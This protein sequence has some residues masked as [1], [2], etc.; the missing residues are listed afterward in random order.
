M[1][2][3]ILTLFFF[4]LPLLLP[5]NIQQ[6]A[7]A[8]VNLQW[9]R[10]YNGP[11]SSDDAAQ[12]ITID[13]SGNVYITGS[14]NVLG[15]VYDYATVKYSPSGET[16][17]VRRFHQGINFNGGRDIIVDESY[18]VYVT[19]SPVTIKYDR[20]GNIL[21]VFDNNADVR[22]M[23]RDNQGNLYITGTSSENFVTFKLN[24]NGILIW[25]STYNGPANGIDRAQ[26]LV[27]DNSNNIIVTGWSQGSGTLYDYAT[28]KYTSFGGTVW[29][30]RYNGP[31]P[32]YPHDFGEA[33]AVDDIGNVFVT[34]YSIGTNGSSDYL[35]IKYD[36][37][38]N[39]IWEARYDIHGD[40]GYDIS[41]DR[42][43]NIFVTGVT[44]VYDYTTL[45][46]NNSGN[47]IWAQTIPGTD[48]PPLPA[49][50]LDTLGNVYVAASRQ[51]DDWADFII[52]K[53][54]NNGIQQ[55][56]T[57]YPGFG[58]GFHYSND[59]IIDRNGIVYVTGQGYGSGFYDYHTVK[60]S[61][62]VGIQTISIEIPAD[63]SLSQN[64]PN[65]FNPSTVIRYR[66]PVNSFV[67]L[68]IYDILGREVANLV[69]GEFK[70]GTYEIKWD[71]NDLM[72]QMSTSGIYFYRLT[73]GDYTESKKMILLR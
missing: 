6:V 40:A 4:H 7:K 69:N 46:Y 66:L 72:N 63:F 24:S 25:T 60:Y 52:V 11:T 22:K 41:V 55:W 33:V 19:G 67:I 48:F 17:W 54:N 47:L 71:G 37:A 16:L 65:P 64:Y 35:T 57:Q 59:I 45:K 43:G 38:G 36:A 10:Q 13:D 18:N 23:T 53:Y 70:A 42:A 12:A 32:S 39:S 44:T 26:N 62:I 73:A 49:M 34:G 29:V 2:K 30:R 51:R 31:H 20:D 56:I 5:H 3:I 68:K 9:A 1:K 8:Q 15:T 27:L 50:V 21:W 61:Q 58:I 14:S 28:I